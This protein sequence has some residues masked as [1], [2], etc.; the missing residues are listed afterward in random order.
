MEAVR[1]PALGPT[2]ITRDATASATAPQSSAALVLG[3]DSHGLAVVRA[4]ARAG[5]AVYA[6]EHD[7]ALP[8]VRSWCPRQVFLRPNPDLD[9]LYDDLVDV[10]HALAHHD[11]V[12]LL[13]MNDRQVGALAGSLARLRPLYRL[14]WADAADEVLRLQRKDRL[15]QHCARRGLRSPA[16]ELVVAPAALHAAKRLAFPVIAKPVHPLSGFKTVLAH[17]FEDLQQQLASHGDSF[18]VVVQEYVPGD[19]RQIFFAALMLDRGRVVA[20]LCGRKLA[21]FPPA[22]GQTTAAETVH[23]P[24][25]QALAQR[26]FADSRISGPVSLEVKRD[27]EGRFWVIEPT[28]GRTDFWVGL[29][30]RAGFNLPLLEHQVACGLRP[31]DL[32]AWRPAQWYDSERDPLALLKFVWK[33]RRGLAA[34]RCYSFADL[35]DWPPMVAALPRL[36]ERAVHGRFWRGFGPPRSTP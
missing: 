2:A 32:P 11:T 30:I 21:S 36:F 35:R 1:P 29:C 12:S 14:A 31:A 8:G 28:V 24:E 26:F 4:L 20:S 17:R 16:S 6:L 27:P 34:R 9:R 25:V 13:A 22:R 33:A 3:L 23:M 19:D 18:P 5:V 15:M 7:A 10:R